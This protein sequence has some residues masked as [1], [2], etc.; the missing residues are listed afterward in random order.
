MQHSDTCDNQPLR[1]TT[2]SALRALSVCFAVLSAAWCFAAS[3]TAQSAGADLAALAQRETVQV[4]TVD[5]DGT[6][7]E[8]TIWIVTLDGGVYIRTS[9][10][11][12]WGDNAER[13][14]SIGLGDGDD[15]HAGATL[16]VRHQAVTEPE[17]RS[18]VIAVFREKYG[19]SD[20]LINW[21]RGEARI[22]S[23][24]EVGS[25]DAAPE[26]SENPETP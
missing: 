1:P 7:S 9:D 21:F 11:S 4:L 2:V 20:A 25:E 26:A 23:L 19:L 17:T 24:E 12:D 10:S 8:T 5:A 13:S 18:R 22:W 3:L 16:R 6:P 14:S 15:V